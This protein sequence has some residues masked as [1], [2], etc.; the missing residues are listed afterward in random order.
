MWKDKSDSQVSK[1]MISDAA[2]PFVARGGRLFSGQV[3]ST[4]PGIKDGDDV[5]IVDRRER[6]V[7]MLRIYT[8]Q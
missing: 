8:G 2:V 1:V 5:L 4:D 3:I 6:P 7:R